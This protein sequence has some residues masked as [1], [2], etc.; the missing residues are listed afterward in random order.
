MSVRLRINDCNRRRVA[1]IT[2]DLPIADND[3]L[4]TDGRNM[5]DVVHQRLL[6][7]ETELD[8]SSFAATGHSGVP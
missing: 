3:A 1:T 7:V 8:K 6:E 5:N 4:T 2:V